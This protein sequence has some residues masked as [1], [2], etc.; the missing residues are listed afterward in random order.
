MSPAV[1]DATKVHVHR[2]AG[3]RPDVLAHYLKALGVLRLLSEQADPR[4]RGF[5]QRESF[6]LVTKLSEQEVVEF[7]VRSYSPTA[8]V[9]PWQKGSGFFD[10][11]DP[12][13]TPLE[14][15][16]APRFAGFRDGIQAARSLCDEQATAIAA[17][18]E[19]KA[20]PK[21]IKDKQAKAALRKSS[22]YKA[23][24][25]AVD[26]RIRALKASM[27]PL[28]RQLWRGPHLEW[29]NAAVVLED[30]REARYPAL[31]GTGGNDGNF[32]FSN[33]YQKRLA[34]LF[35]LTH[36]EAAPKPP[37]LALFRS[38]VF[39]PPSQGLERNP[40][41]QFLP[42]GAGGVNSTTGPSGGSLLNPWDFVLA[43]EGALLFH[44]SAT[45]RCSTAS[46][47][48]S[49]PFA[50]SGHAMGYASAG[51]HDEKNRRGEQWMPLWTRPWTLTEVRRVLSE[52][53]CQVGSRTSREPLDL[54]RAIA[55]LGVARG[56]DAF[57]RFGYIERNG[58]SNLAVPLGRWPVRVQAHAELIEDLDQ[59]LTQLHR[60]AR[61]DNAPASVVAAER[62]LGDVVMAA[63]AHDD[64]P[65]RWQSVLLALTAVEDRLVASRR[66]TADRRLWPVP[67]LRP[68]WVPAIDDGSAEV[69][70]ALALA[71][72]AAGH[73]SGVPVDPVRH[74]WLPLDERGRG[75]VVHESGLANDPRVV[76]FGRDPEA[77]LIALVERRLV[78]ASR[79]T[80]R[81][82]PISAAP[83]CAALGSD[84]ARLV[85]GGVD[86]QRCVGLARA[87]MALDWRELRSARGQLRLS[88]PS[89]AD[90]DEA[91]EPDE[92]WK[93]VRL[94]NLP[95]PLAEKQSIAVDPAVVRRLSSGDAAKGIELA[96]HRLKVAGIVPGFVAGTLSAAQARR[97]VASL[98]FP[99]S[100]DDARRWAVSLT[101][102]TSNSRS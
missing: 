99:I 11:G 32:D 38:S 80:G 31:L 7:F 22:A 15:S 29:L 69:R 34:D 95:W 60:A 35:D 17:E 39:G 91:Q 76:C 72:A 93:V 10:E 58:Q 33:N 43:L 92:C 102:Q 54:A 27:I 71:G 94:A 89:R 86:L 70:L 30:K 26:R 20:E 9:S 41:G 61:S 81:L 4:A 79:S 21:A 77:D 65:G 56:I 36:A 100:K 6:V 18:R 74:H 87:L 45:R 14:K 57:Q 24:L 51:A 84:L 49:A 13:L 97:V 96:L 55:R 73:R 5:W 90:L 28:C 78:D 85:A 64:E 2:L 48:A 101:P 52:G 37:A 12:G 47:H 42:G 50:V 68:G 63:L 59:W 25:A 16:S 40:I 1:N 88:R 82:L 44:G 46:A 8:L 53:R 23:R 67:P 66:F 83:D 62:R 98:A 19:I 75:F 3:C